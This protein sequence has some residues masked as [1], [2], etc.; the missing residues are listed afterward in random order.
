MNPRMPSPSV[1]LIARLLAGLTVLLAGAALAEQPRACFLL[2]ELGTTEVVRK[3]G[4][5]C[6]E[7][8]SPASTFKIPHGLAALESKV[9]T[10]DEVIRI[11]GKQKIASWEGTHTLRTAIRYSVVPFFQETARR[12]GRKR[13]TA[14]LEKFD[15]GNKNDSGRIDRFWLNGRLKISP[16]EQLAFLEK[17]FTGALPVEPKTLEVVK[18]ALE[19]PAGTYVAGGTEVPI[20]GWPAGAKLFGKTGSTGEPARVGWYVGAVERDGR[21]FVFVSRM[22]GVKSGAAAAAAAVRELKAAGVY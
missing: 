5:E 12:I 19:Q 20:E 7:R 8:T 14:W 15:Y 9:I 22:R 17:F 10:E 16:V 21:R 18:S 13:M 6:D 11:K 1:V 2:H 3:G 4:G